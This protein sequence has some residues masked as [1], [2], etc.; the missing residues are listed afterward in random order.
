MHAQVGALKVDEQ[1]LALRWRPGRAIWVMPGL[2]DHT[3]EIVRWLAA[4]SSDT[5][6]NV[7]DQYYPAHK[8][9]TLPRFSSINRNLRASEFEEALEA[10]EAA[11]LWRLDI[12][13][14]NVRP[15]GPVW[16]PWMHRLGE[17]SCALRRSR[18]GCGHHGRRLFVWHAALRSNRSRPIMSHIAIASIVDAPAERHLSPGHRFD[19]REFRFTK[20]QPRDVSW[21]GR[22]RS[23]CA[24]CGTPLTFMTGPDADE[25]DVTVA[26]FDRP[27]AVSPADHIWVEDRLPW[28]RLADELPE[29]RQGR[30]D[31]IST[32]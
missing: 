10:A 3:R 13:W 17:R 14:R 11:G 32:D 15:H 9:A 18:H 2:L 27:N 7:M 20:G 6:V 12:R 30:P 23:F 4:L 16:L 8:A 31:D 29:Y 25:I 24:E 28:I 19:D 1:G 5:Y 21:A 26:S 22:I